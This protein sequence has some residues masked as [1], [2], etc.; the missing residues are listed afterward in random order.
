MQ[1]VQE[2][3]ASRKGIVHTH[4]SENR[5]EV[6]I[7][8]KLYGCENIEAFEKLKL[9]GPQLVLAHCIHLNENEEN[10][11]AR[12]GTHVSH[13]PSSNLKLAS[14]VARVP[15]LKAKGVSVSLGADGAPCNNN[16]NMFQEMRLA[17]LLQKPR[18]GPTTLKAREA[19]EM[20]TIDGAHALGLRSEVG[21]LEIGKKAD[22]V[23]V[24]LREPS[25]A[26][27]LSEKEPE[28]AYS[29]LVYSAGPSSVRET[30]V[31]GRS[32][33]REGRYPGTPAASIVDEA[34]RERKRLLARL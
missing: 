5:E 34:L 30:W 15:E 26:V 28:L 7:V 17:S 20:A 31:E 23:R 2:L 4:S 24:N 21:S 1:S 32:V 22:M 9:T 14:G 19:F 18:L 13:C 27:E 6:E 11:L 3:S 33:Y 29:A 16:L 10:I 12:S 25:V 8:R